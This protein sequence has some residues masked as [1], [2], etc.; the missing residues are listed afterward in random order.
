MLSA[1]VFKI[2]L[3]TAICAAV[4]IA[5]NTTE[6]F[7]KF[8]PHKLMLESSRNNYVVGDQI[9]LVASVI[10]NK[11]TAIRVYKDRAKS[12]SLFIRNA[13]GNSPDFSDSDTGPY[14]LID[15]SSREIDRRKIELIKISPRKPFRLNLKGKIMETN[16][17]N[18]TFDFGEF[19]SF[20]KSNSGNFL[21]SGYWTPINPPAEDSLEDYTNSLIITVSKLKK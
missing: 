17:K 4:L 21:I 16:S 15:S 1:R 11:P 9:S 5:C 8:Y 12:F 19:G 14:N 6:T 7:D 2:V 20:N 3:A 13:K 10:P 18:V